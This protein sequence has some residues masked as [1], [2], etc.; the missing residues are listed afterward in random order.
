M[1]ED[2][3]FLLQE[4][5]QKR[6]QERTGMNHFIDTCLNNQT[7]AQREEEKK[8]EEGLMGV[9]D[10]R[11]VPPRISSE[12][13]RRLYAV[14]LAATALYYRYENAEVLS[15]EDISMLLLLGYELMKIEGGKGMIPAMEVLKKKKGEVPHA[16]SILPGSI[17]TF[18]IID[19]L[20]MPPHSEDSTFDI[21]E[22]AHKVYQWSKNYLK[23]YPYVGAVL[24]TERMRSKNENTRAKELERQHRIRG[25]EANYLISWFAVPFRLYEALCTSG[26]LATLPKGK[27]RQALAG[28]LKELRQD[29]FY[30][31]DYSLSFLESLPRKEGVRR[32][33]EA[34]IRS[35]VL[36]PNADPSIQK[37]IYDEI[38]DILTDVDFPFKDTSEEMGD[39]KETDMAEEFFKLMRD[40]DKR[41]ANSEAV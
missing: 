22:F 39:G 20:R 29:L 9:N 37:E 24:G 13:A 10:R 6:D 7:D 25:Q 17:F 8:V 11:F 41:D 15:K 21:L 16:L 31:Q 40:H 32:V 3:F 38:F 1:T 27:Q 34:L 26:T 14:R 2:I 4:F 28:I 23:K 12:G 35:F 30:G 36:N 18:P 19:Y 5:Q 33:F